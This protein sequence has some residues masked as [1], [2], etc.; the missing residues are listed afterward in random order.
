MHTQQPATVHTHVRVALS[1]TFYGGL[2]Y[3]GSS[4]MDG[5]RSRSSFGGLD[6]RG[7]D[8]AAA[9]TPESNIRQ[10]LGPEPP[11]PPPAGYAPGA[12]GVGIGEPPAAA[13]QQPSPYDIYTAFPKSQPTKLHYHPVCTRPTSSHAGTN[14]G[15]SFD[16]EGRC[17]GGD[18]P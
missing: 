16:L 10:T 8:V 2:P 11:Q 13:Y 17:C 5:R 7:P 18:Y 3:A 9:W 4:A 15:S 1:P 12:L 14:G 6:E